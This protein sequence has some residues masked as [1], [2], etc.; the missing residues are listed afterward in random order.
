[1]GHQNLLADGQ[2]QRG[3]YL[4]PQGKGYR[5][6]VVVSIDPPTLKSQGEARGY[7]L[8]AYQ[9]EVERRLN[10]EL[11]K[12]YNVKINWDVVNDITY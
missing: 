10:D 3:V 6:L 1:M 5:A 4:T 11:R 7:Y 9:N 12:K 8:N 2:W